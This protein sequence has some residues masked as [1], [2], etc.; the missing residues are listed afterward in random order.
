MRQPSSGV[1]QVAGHLAFLRGQQ[2]VASLALRLQ[3]LAGPT[4]TQRRAAEP[5]CATRRLPRASVGHDGSRCVT[6]DL[7]LEDRHWQVSYM[8]TSF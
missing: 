1:G 5:Y 4:L 3:D 6:K 7:G 2:S 8:N